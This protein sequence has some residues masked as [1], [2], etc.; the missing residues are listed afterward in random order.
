MA[1]IPNSNGVEE[2]FIGYLVRLAADGERG[3][4][5]A[6]RRGLGKPPGTVAEMFPTV[7]PWISE[8]TEGQPWLEDSLFVVASLFALHPVNRACDD[9]RRPWSL[10]AAMRVLADS[11]TSD[12]PERRLV[13][14]LKC[15]REE[16]P[17]HLRGVVSLLAGKQIPIDYVE[18]L[19][20]VR[21]WGNED[22]RVQR[23]WARAFWGGRAADAAPDAGTAGEVAADESV[24]GDS[25]DES[26]AQEAE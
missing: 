19:R 5:A 17:A 4:L 18:L 21:W 1:D 13:A 20:D 26:D 10:G 8:R 6:L 2:R 16:L 7:A 9:E 14:M 23:K 22:R 25:T 3:R 11:G 24:E 15:R 12:G